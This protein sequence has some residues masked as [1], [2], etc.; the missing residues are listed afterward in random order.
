MSEFFTNTC[1]QCNKNDYDGH[2]VFHD[3]NLCENCHVESSSQTNSNILNEKNINPEGICGNCNKTIGDCNST[4]DDI[5]FGKQTIQMC[6]ACGESIDPSLEQVYHPGIFCPDCLIG[7]G[8]TYEKRVEVEYR[9]NINKIA[10]YMPLIFEKL[11]EIE[12]NTNQTVKS[13]VNTSNKPL[14]NS[15]YDSLQNS[16]YESMNENIYHKSENSS[17][18]V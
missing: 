7:M 17:E 10:A 5:V 13:F 14:Q 3:H 16:M 9:E 15:I 1:N 18:N 8:Q 11:K 4:Q 2:I 6:D 12:K